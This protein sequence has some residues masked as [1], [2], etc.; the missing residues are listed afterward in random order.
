MRIIIY[1]L[2]GCI[3]LAYIGSAWTDLDYMLSILTSLYIPVCLIYFLR[4][5]VDI[6]EKETWADLLLVFMISC[7]ITF[8]FGFILTFRDSVFTTLHTDNP[9]FVDMLLGVAFLEE[10][11]KIIPVLIIL[12]LMKSINEPIDCNPSN[13]S[14]LFS[15]KV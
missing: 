7:I 13:Q 8:L 15:V 11:V 6:F 14:G 2:F 9:S 4:E 5:K 3:S 10:I 12:K 1:I